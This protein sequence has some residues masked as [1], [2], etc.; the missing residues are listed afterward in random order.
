[1]IITLQ[2]LLSVLIILKDPVSEFSTETGQDSGNITKTQSKATPNESSSQ[3]TN[4]DEDITLVNV[5][6][7]ADKEIFDVNVLDGEEVFV[8]QEVD[9]K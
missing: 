2:R 4:S 3:R 9:V 8:E 5:H 6:D 1:H 7:D